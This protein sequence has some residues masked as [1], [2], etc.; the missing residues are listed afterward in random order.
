LIL[1]FCAATTL[2][3]LLAT[4]AGAPQDSKPKVMIL[5][6]AHLVW[7][8][9]IHNAT[10][11]DNP[12]SPK[13]QAQIAEIVERLARFHP[14]KVLIEEKMDD[15]K[16]MRDYRDYVIGR[17]SLPADEAHQFGFR[18]AKRSGNSTIYP[19]DTWGP[20][21][22]DDNSASGKRID[23]YLNAHLGAVNEP[24]F[25]AFLARQ[26][27]LERSDT[28]L[29][30]LRYLN[31]DAAIRANAGWYTIVDGMGR[32]A[33]DAGAMYT[34]QWYTRNLYIFSNILSVIRPGDRVVVIFG[35]GHEYQLR[36]LAR[37]DPTLIYVDPLHYLK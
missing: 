25:A 18:L 21:I 3:S 7:R 20:S 15:A 2:L 27:A 24:A 6:V 1:R 29:Q 10:F 34:A 13:R 8:H 36:E 12:L 4:A 17:F 16:T 33:D 22:Y 19:V 11:A 5:G 23:A 35:Q 37:L 9:D 28:Y 26:N 31:T 32:N 30:V 14:T